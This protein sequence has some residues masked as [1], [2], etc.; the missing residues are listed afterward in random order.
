MGPRFVEG[1]DVGRFHGV[2]PATAAK[3]RRLG[4]E[5]GADLRAKD[6]A[7]LH[8]RFGKAGAYYFDIARGVDE[9]PVR[10]DRIRKSIGAEKT[11]MADVVRFAEMREALQPILDKVWGAAERMEVRAR[12]VTR[13]VKSADCRQSTRARARGHAVGGRAQLEAIALDLLRPVAEDAPVRLLG[14]SLSA[15]DAGEARASSQFSMPF[16]A[17]VG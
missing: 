5:T 10:V 9:R 12:S 7:F 6:L 14:V 3:M 16:E 11:F 17:M 13:K 2:G 8:A 1:L 15:L 4:I